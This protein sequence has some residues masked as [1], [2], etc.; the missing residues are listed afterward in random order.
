LAKRKS[1]F[2]QIQITKTESKKLKDITKT[3]VNNKKISKNCNVFKNQKAQLIWNKG[4][5]MDESF[6]SYTV[7]FGKEIK[8]S[9]P[10]VLIKRFHWEN[11][12]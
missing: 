4:F 5:Q 1:E 6:G 9:H 10:S 8:P 7:Y 2:V 11:V 12:A 3:P